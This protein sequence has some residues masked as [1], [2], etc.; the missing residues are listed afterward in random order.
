MQELIHHPLAALI[1]VVTAGLL[2]GRVQVAGL[3]LGS[4][5]VIFTALAAGHFGFSIPKEAGQLG[6][7]LFVY[8]VGLAA[9]P[10]FFRTFVRKGR[11]FAVLA[12]VLVAS[13][14]AAT[15]IASLALGLPP[16][17][18]AGAFAGAL[19]S[20]P[21][22]A[23]ALEAAPGGSS[24]VSYGLAYPIGLVGVVLFVQ[25][26]P[27][28]LGASLEQLGVQAASASDGERIVRR[29]V[30]VLNPGVEGRRLS[31]L[32]PIAEAN[33]QISRQLEGDKLRPVGPD[34]SLHVGQHVLVVVR[35]R[36]LDQ[37]VTYLGKISE[38]AGYTL[39]AESE[40]MQVVVSSKEVIDK[41]LR[42][43]RF[44]GRFGV[45]VS[46]LRRHGVEFV[47][48]AGDT[49]EYGDQLTAVGERAKLDDFA[50]YV[51]HRQRLF[52]ETDLISVGVGLMAGI[53]V[54]LIKV[55][56]GEASF[57]LGLAGGP[58]LI[59]LLLG[60]YGRVGPVK[61][62][63][64]RAAHLLLQECGLILFLA[65]AGAA[66]GGGLGETLA[67]FG[68]QLLAVA[69]A[70]MLVSILVGYVAGRKVFGLSLLETLGAVCGGMTS[71]P[72]LGAITSKTDAD[73]PVIAYAAA[74]PAALILMTVFARLVVSTLGG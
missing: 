2:L 72:G 7:A 73:A 64:P 47:P 57:Q 19:T 35:E 20:T 24:A 22:L 49:V 25:L 10:G 6:L 40:R 18:A 36:N 71:T 70:A 1:A 67:A 3:S 9:G 29:L 58:L 27:R 60:H 31:S 74:Y 37:V 30:E 28:L 59:G 66:A 44:L 69:A 68:P 61:G 63:L 38:R 21:G 34:F 23:A 33:C 26:A 5:G 45:T 51:G 32:E 55:E 11:V 62:H 54:G 12:A 41:T 56:L 13:G 65:A 42:E 17:L 52:D 46:R 50:A 14:A 8:C 16:D 48:K 43:L 4:S 39:D 53:I 15:A